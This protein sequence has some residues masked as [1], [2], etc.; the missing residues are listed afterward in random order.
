MLFHL[1]F[2]LIQNMGF[3]RNDIKIPET[4]WCDLKKDVFKFHW[5]YFSFLFYISLKIQTML[6]ILKY[7]VKRF[8]LLLSQYYILKLFTQ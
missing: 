6:L 7:T 8:T 3:K 1:H 2:S 5:H 4:S